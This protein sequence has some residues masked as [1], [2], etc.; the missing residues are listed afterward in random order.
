MEQ[1]LVSVIIPVYKVYGYIDKCVYSV[2]NQTYTNL[3]IILVDDG[4]PD[5]CAIKCDEW[6]EKDARIT[7]IHKLN[8]GLSDA[9]NYGMKIIRGDYVSFIDSDDYISEDFYEVLLST[10]LKN[11]SDIVE[12]GF[13]RF[14]ESG[15]FEE[16]HDDLAVS[17]YSA[18]GGLSALIDENP[19]RQHVWDKLYKHEVV[20]NIFFEVGKQHEDE[21]WTYQIFGR[22]EKITKTYR[23][24]YFYFQRET[25]IMGNGYNL[26]R[27]DALEGKW[28]RQN[29]IEKYYPELTLQAKLDFFGSCIYLL[30]CVLKY[31]SGKE[32]RQATSIIRKYKKM[33][34]ITFSDIK[35]IR[36]GAR[37][38]YYLAKLNLYLCCKLRAKFNIG[39]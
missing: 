35:A 11:D 5:D 38:Y 13:T 39:F 6:A 9:R 23:T 32:K 24:M 26:R 2:V 12:C 16:Y 22:A 29:Y 21:Y 28:N 37:K 14:Y 31:M 7:V 34:R 8:G 1:P 33:C 4:S 30:Q 3:Q 19:F 20:K 10:A 36:S 15:E 18:S 25:S 17:D 27:L